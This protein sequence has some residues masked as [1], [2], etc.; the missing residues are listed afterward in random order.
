M[1]TEEKRSLHMICSQTPRE[2]DGSSRGSGGE[3]RGLLEAT[4]CFENPQEN[5]FKYLILF[6]FLSVNFREIQCFR[7][8]E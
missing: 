8:K 2:T 4:E 7:I 6:S 5:K 3:I 1:V